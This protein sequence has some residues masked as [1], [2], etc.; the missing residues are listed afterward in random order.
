MTSMKS[1]DP[2][3]SLPLSELSHLLEN[4]E[5]VSLLDSQVSAL[6]RQLEGLRGLYSELLASVADLKKSL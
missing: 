6:T 1:S 3:V 5:R 4:A 2:L